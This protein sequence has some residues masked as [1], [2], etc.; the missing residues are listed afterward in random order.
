MNSKALRFIVTPVTLVALT[1]ALAQG[2]AW[3]QIEA[4]ATAEAALPKVEAEIPA[5]SPKE[6]KV[7]A[8]YIYNFSRY[9]E[10]PAVT[11][12]DVKKPFVIGVLGSDPL[13]NQLDRLAAKKKVRNRKIVIHRFESLDQY[14]ECQMLFVTRSVSD[15]LFQD[16]LERANDEPVLVVSE[17]PPETREGSS[18]QIFIDPAGK[19]GFE[20]DVDVV[21]ARQL[22]VSAKLL[23]LASVP[24]KGTK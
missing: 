13:G 22:Q 2:V 20:I 1:I 15:D 23:K 11:P 8:A 4:Y 12:E 24:S 21:N 6:Q 9:F 19:I 16:A 10:W 5:P 14:R 7:K 18:V 17:R 3:S